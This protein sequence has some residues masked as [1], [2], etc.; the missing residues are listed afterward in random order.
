MICGKKLGRMPYKQL[1]TRRSSGFTLIELMVS[2]AIIGLLASVAVPGYMRNARQA[3]ST[4][5]RVQLQ[6]IYAAS[7]SYII[8]LHNAAGS[9]TPVPPQ[10]PDPEPA[11]PAGSCCAPAPS[12]LQKCAPDPTLWATPT[13]R[14]LQFS[15]DTPH[16]YHYAYT[17]TG[18]AS[19]GPGSNFTAGAYGDLNCDGH[20]STYELYGV[21]NNIDFDV[22]GSAGFY[23]N[24]PL[25]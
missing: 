18:S 2:V 12:L 16:Y 23:M 17:S 5:A 19:P 4:E 6:K 15:I 25:E 22:H 1:P 3:K 10:F 11:T 14:S 13:W 7:R 24:D 9:T 21:W 8:E 20:Y